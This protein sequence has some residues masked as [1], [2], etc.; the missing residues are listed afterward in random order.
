MYKVILVLALLFCFNANA[1]PDNSEIHSLIRLLNESKFSPVDEL[2]S[3][4]K[5]C[6]SK[7]ECDALYKAILEETV[8]KD[9]ISHLQIQYAKALNSFGSQDEAIAL[10]KDVSNRLNKASS[11]V[12][13]EYYLT[14]GTVMVSSENPIMAQTNYRKALKIAVQSN[15]R[16]SQLKCLTSVGL[17]FTAQHQLDSAFHYYFEAKKFEKSGSNRNN[18]YLKLNLAWT[19][20]M[21]GE[22]EKAKEFFIQSLDL[23]KEVSDY[24]AEIRTFGNIADIYSKQDSLDLAHFYYQKGLKSANKHGFKLDVF[25]FERAIGELY[26]KERKFEQAFNHFKFSDS[27]RESF[28]QEE[29]TTQSITIEK[30]FQEQLEAQKR[31]IAKQQLDFEKRKN[32][33]LSILAGLIFVLA[34]VLAYHFVI[35]KR[36]NFTLLSKIIEQDRKDEKEQAIPLSSDSEI[37]EMIHALEEFII[38]K[39]NYK[40]DNLTLE[41]VAKKLKTNRTYLSESVNTHYNMNFSRWLNE[42]RIKESRK[43]L[44]SEKNDKYSIE[45]IATMVGFNSISSFNSNFKTITGITPSFYRKNRL[46]N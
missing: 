11:S 23:F 22:L 38:V 3:N 18:L 13:I 32:I 46:I 21:A 12:Q 5:K 16:N 42:I 44:G 24:S 28:K 9:A 19:N 30:E 43:L 34:I 7:S 36:K 41:K 37:I 4:F 29:I 26:A 14:M 39:E 8:G 27:I 35:L 15:D 1:Y 45:G 2:I 17:T 10:L 20:S 33:L 25:R 40:M 6:D 31:E